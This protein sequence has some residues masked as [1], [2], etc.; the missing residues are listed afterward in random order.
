MGSVVTDAQASMGFQ[1][2]KPITQNK[3]SEIMGGN[4]GLSIRNTESD[5]MRASE[6]N[7]MNNS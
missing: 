7:P 6:G 5:G 1:T 3:A 4:N 2:D